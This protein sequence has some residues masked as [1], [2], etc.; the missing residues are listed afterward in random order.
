MKSTIKA[1]FLGLVVATSMSLVACSDDASV[2]STEAANQL[3]TKFATLQP[4]VRQ[5]LI[6]LLEPHLLKLTIRL[7]VLTLKPKPPEPRSKT[8]TYST[9]KKLKWPF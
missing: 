1:S 3:D 4:V 5:V 8:S 9:K 7:M 6:I 2:S